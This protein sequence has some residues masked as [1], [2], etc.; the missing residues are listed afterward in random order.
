[1]SEL[2]TPVTNGGGLFSPSS[3]YVADFL[4][5]RY[6]AYLS[7]VTYVAATI[8]VCYVI[9]GGIKYMQAGSDPKKTAAARSIIISAIIGA[10]II[11]GAYTL[12][13][14]GIAISKLVSSQQTSAGVIDPSTGGGSSSSGSS[15]SGSSGTCKE[16]SG[17]GPCQPDSGE[18]FCSNSGGYMCTTNADC[19]K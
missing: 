2:I 9:W 3:S 18:C 15:S 14:V 16:A 7:Y 8:V 19:N 6:S 5:N 4:T 1:M 11:I 12:I 10:S 13:S 17:G